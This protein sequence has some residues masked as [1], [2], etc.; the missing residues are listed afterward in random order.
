MGQ[1]IE[2]GVHQRVELRLGGSDYFRV[3]V[4]Q[5]EYADA[6]DEIDVAL[7]FFIPDF[8]IAPTLDADGMND[9]KRAAD[10]RKSHVGVLPVLRMRLMTDES[11]T[12]QWLQTKKNGLCIPF[13]ND[14]V[15]L[16]D[17]KCSGVR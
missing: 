5:I 6:T 2:G 7:A 12:L 3:S 17:S 8:C 11:R 10:M 1:G 16:R 14:S 13:T 15:G 9:S 4:T